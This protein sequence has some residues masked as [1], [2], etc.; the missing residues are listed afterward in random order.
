M[1]APRYDEGLELR[2]P[3]GRQMT[4]AD[5]GDVVA[6]SENQGFQ[7]GNRGDILETL[8]C[9]MRSADHQSDEIRTGP[10][11]NAPIDK[12]F[13]ESCGMN[14]LIIGLVNSLTLS[15]SPS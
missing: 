14:R 5:C 8:V 13:S 10:A 15:R 2:Q 11:V 3:T 12:T 4:D 9:Y 7:S 1:P 6:Q